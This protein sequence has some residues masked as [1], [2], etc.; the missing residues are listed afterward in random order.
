[1]AVISALGRLKQENHKFETKLDYIVR[2]YLKEKKATKD[3]IGIY[4]DQSELVKRGL[5][6]EKIEESNSLIELK[7][8]IKV[9]IF[10]CDQS[11]LLLM[12]SV[13]KISTYNN[14]P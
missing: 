9:N 11:M 10:I 3:F 12:G 1:M 13:Q 5:G 7:Y 14:Y 2:P 4:T 8:S 6:I